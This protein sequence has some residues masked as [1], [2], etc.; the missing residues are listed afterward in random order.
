MY[1]PVW[2]P[3]VSLSVFCATLQVLLTPGFRANLTTL[4]CNVTR[5]FVTSN[6]VK[7]ATR[8]AQVSKYQVILNKIEFDKEKLI[9]LNREENTNKG[10]YGQQQIIHR[11]PLLHR[12]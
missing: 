12:H 7:P 1:V 3:G 11:K 5:T 6:P 9:C 8:S 10:L 2:R 4:D